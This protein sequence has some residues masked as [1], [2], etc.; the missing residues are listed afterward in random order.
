MQRG[1]RLLEL[2]TQTRGGT[3]KRARLCLSVGDEPS[4]K[5]EPA[6]T[7]SEIQAAPQEAELTLFPPAR[8]STWTASAAT[9]APASQPAPAAAPAPAS[10][11]GGGWGDLLSKNKEQASKAALAAQ[12]EIEK[13]KAGMSTSQ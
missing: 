1:F 7:A 2:V 6:A 12:E 13:A 5:A 11:G 8:A 10:S 9:S 4:G 3:I